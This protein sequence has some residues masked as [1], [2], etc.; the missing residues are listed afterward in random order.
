MSFHEERDFTAVKAGVSLARSTSV[1]GDR[2]S[3][4]F[5]PSELYLIVYLESSPFYASPSFAIRSIC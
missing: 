2:I 3:S 5:E 1:E 4:E